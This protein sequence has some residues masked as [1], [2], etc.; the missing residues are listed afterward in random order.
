MKLSN[1][2]HVAPRTINARPVLDN[3][4][5]IVAVVLFAYHLISSHWKGMNESIASKSAHKR[6]QSI[7]QTLL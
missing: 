2:A 6:Y 3:H 5:A 1:L 7:V 4:P